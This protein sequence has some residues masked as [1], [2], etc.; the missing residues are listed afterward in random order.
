MVYMSTFKLV[1][2]SNDVLSDFPSRQ[3]EK[4]TLLS[5]MRCFCRYDCLKILVSRSSKFANIEIL[6]K[7]HVPLIFN[8]LKLIIFLL[9]FF[10][11]SRKFSKYFK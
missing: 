9:I 7:I 11:F 6:N 1:R 4:E 3:N 5:L 8:L 2:S 10:H